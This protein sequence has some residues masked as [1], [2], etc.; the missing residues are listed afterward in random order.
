MPMTRAQTIFLGLLA[1]LALALSTSA[2]ADGTTFPDKTIG[3]ESA[4]VIIDEYISL[5]CPH[6]AEFYLHTLPEIEKRYVK[7]GKVKMVIHDYPLDGLS[8]KA[9]ALARCMPPDE[10]FPFLQILYDNQ[11]KW[12]V[13]GNADKILVQYARLGGLD[14]DRARF[15]LNDPNIQGAIVAERSAAEQMYDIQSTP[16]FVFNKGVEKMAGASDIDGFAVI[17]DRML[18][19]SKK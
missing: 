13:A 11:A 9:A 12:A 4:P 7:T 16:T 5:T 18:A 10:Y 2:W 8:L 19:H 3:K 15:C 6:C 1:F 14:E 17:I